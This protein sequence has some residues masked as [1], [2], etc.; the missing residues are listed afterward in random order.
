MKCLPFAWLC[1]VCVLPI[2]VCAD[3]V[4]GIDI[5]SS[6]YSVNAPWSYTWSIIDN[7]PSVPYSSGSGNYGGTSSDGS[8][9]SVGLTSAGPFPPGISSPGI[10]GYT[11]IGG[12]GGANI[13]G[14]SGAFNIAFQNETSAW[15]N[16]V[17]GMPWYNGSDGH[18]YG[19]S[20]VVNVQ[21]QASWTFRPTA[22]TM[23]IGLIASDFDQ[24]ANCVGLSLTLS[25]VTHPSV[26]LAFRPSDTYRYGYGQSG[27]PVISVTNLF[28]VNTS[29]TYELTVNGWANTYDD[30][31]AYQYVDVSIVAVPEPGTCSVCL[32]GLLSVAWFKRWPTGGATPITA[33][34]SA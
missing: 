27:G 2:S 13:Y 16:S 7:W 12:S 21:A 22:D 34:S 8:P 6:V 15:H 32:L 24:Y 3:V 1:L 30:D 25:D 28:S 19:L 18:R 20:A 29:D 5:L 33:C 14:W 4:N 9:L 10:G 17:G 31:S 23:Q 11:Y 26:L